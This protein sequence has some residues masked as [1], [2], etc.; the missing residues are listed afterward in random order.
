[1]I[2]KAFLIPSKWRFYFFTL[3]FVKPEPWDIFKESSGLS[4]FAGSSDFQSAPLGDAYLFK[5]EIITT[6]TGLETDSLTGL[7]VLVK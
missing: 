7:K 6:E 3:K 1:M 4:N 2:S 5:R